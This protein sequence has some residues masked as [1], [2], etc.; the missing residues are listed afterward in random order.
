[1]ADRSHE[2]NIFEY[3]L[4]RQAS[5]GAAPLRVFRNANMRRGMPNYARRIREIRKNL[6]MNQAEFAAALGVSQGSVSKWEAAK[7]QPRTTALLKIA[8]LAG[9]PSFSLFSGTDHNQ[10]R[11]GGLRAVRVVGSIQSGYGVEAPEW[12]EEQH[13]DLMLPTPPIWGPLELSGWIVRGEEI[14]TNWPPGSYVIAAREADPDDVP[15]G[16]RPQKIPLQN[17][18]VVVVSNKIGH[19]YE[20]TLKRYFEYD[21]KTAGLMHLGN[22]TGSAMRPININIGC[23]NGPD[24]EILGLVIAT[25]RYEIDGDRLT[26]ASVD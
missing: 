1:M 4:Y 22:E 26:Y 24:F 6:G 2:R 5:S 9:L 20:V 8:E 10:K 17:G 13:F 14:W 18:D 7:E 3:E 23:I 11:Q 25:L 15:Q 12:D 16:F 19:L 21:E